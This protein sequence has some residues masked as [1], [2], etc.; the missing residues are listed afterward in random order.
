[1]EIPINEIENQS[2]DRFWQGITFG[3]TEFEVLMGFPDGN[4]YDCL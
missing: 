3:Y 2:R 4:A 1:M